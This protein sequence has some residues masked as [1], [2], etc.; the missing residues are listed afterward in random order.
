MAV[1][2]IK[3]QFEVGRDKIGKKGIVTEK[4]IEMRLYKK[5]KMNLKA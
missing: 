1:L 3:P 5:L 4:N 2:L